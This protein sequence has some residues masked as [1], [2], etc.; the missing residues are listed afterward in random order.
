MPKDDPTELF[1]DTIDAY[2]QSVG[3]EPDEQEMTEI[4]RVVAQEIHDQM[5]K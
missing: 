3:H 4:M 2:A 5:E 1:N